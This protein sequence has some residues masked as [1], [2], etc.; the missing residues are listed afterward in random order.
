MI[1]SRRSV[2]AVRRRT[3]IDAL[4]RGAVPDSGLDLLA[5][6]LDRFEPASGRRTGRGRLGR[7]RCSRPSAASTA[8]ARRSSPV[9]SA[10]GPSGATSPSPR[11]RSPRPRHR[12][13]SWRPS[14]GGSPS[15]STT[16][17]FPPSALRPVVDAWFYALE[18]DALADGASE[19]DLAEA[20]DRA[21]DRAT[22]RGLPARPVLRRG[23][24]RLPR[25]A[26]RQATR[27]PR[28]RYWPGS[29]GSRMS[30][31]P[32]AGPPGCE[33]TSTTSARSASSRGC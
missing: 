22:G 29:A 26:R 16:A 1:E 2:S 25:G 27:R 8:R 10:S 24:A 11:S 17:S 13:T 14:T 21:A 32:R 28:Q 15:G 4:R 18:E 23:A 12:C 7:R 33:A 20:V 6:G 30:R 19:D 5:T 3:A 31:P 9:G